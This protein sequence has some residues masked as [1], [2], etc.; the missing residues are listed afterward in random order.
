MKNSKTPEQAA[1]SK[2]EGPDHVCKMRIGHAIKEAVLYYPDGHDA[3]P[4]IHEGF[5]TLRFK[6]KE[7]SPEL[8]KLLE[9]EFND[10]NGDCPEVQKV[11]NLIQKL[12]LARMLAE[13]IL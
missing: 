5:M 4:G 10:E 9:R 2:I 8:I 3:G 11:L 1:F 13:E 7:V 6:A 12:S